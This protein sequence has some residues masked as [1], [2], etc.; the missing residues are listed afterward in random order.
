MKKS[1]EV[2][3]L[4]E[5]TKIIL[6]VISNGEITTLESSAMTVKEYHDIYSGMHVGKKE[7]TQQDELEWFLGQ[8]IS[9]VDKKSYFAVNS[10]LNFG[11][12]KW[13]KEC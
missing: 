11:Y 7:F 9:I 8:L 3:D 4:L 5:T 6:K 1:N 13:V 12:E 2:K 10:W